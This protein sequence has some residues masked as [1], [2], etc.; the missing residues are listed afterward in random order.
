MGWRCN[1]LCFLLY[2]YS[3][4]Y[5]ACLKPSMMK[6]LSLDGILSSLYILRHTLHNYAHLAP[7]ICDHKLTRKCMSIKGPHIVLIP[8]LLDQ[9]FSPACS[10]PFLSDHNKTV[11][12]K[13]VKESKGHLP[14][15]SST[16]KSQLISYHSGMSLTPH[17]LS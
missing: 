2:V 13:L 9:Y 10:S 11:T 3:L 12:E 14:S 4:L 6:I 8:L 7:G 17:L 5:E 16:I 15:V 1:L